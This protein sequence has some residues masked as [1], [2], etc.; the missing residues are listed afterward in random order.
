[1]KRI[2]LIAAM[3][4]AILVIVLMLQNT[5]PVRT[6]LLFATV[7]MP[8]ALLLLTTVLVGYALGI[9]TAVIWLRPRDSEPRDSGP[10]P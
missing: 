5:E 2:R 6:R 7:E 10:T 1:M 4:L 3:I 8:R 9:L